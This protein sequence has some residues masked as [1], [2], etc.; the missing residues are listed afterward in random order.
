MFTILVSSLLLSPF[1]FPA[2]TW[3]GSESYND[4][5]TIMDL[6][7][8]AELVFE[9]DFEFEKGDL[10]PISSMA[11]LGPNDILLLEKNTGIVHRIIN[12]EMSKE[13]LLDVSVANERERGL[14]GIAVTS[15]ENEE[16]NR[17]T[18]VYLY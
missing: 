3:A 9:N 13:P 1:Y 15:Q 10:S 14:I 18:Y 8:E 4:L 7:L 17:L 5:P 6:K 16:E 2:L 11:V 12:G